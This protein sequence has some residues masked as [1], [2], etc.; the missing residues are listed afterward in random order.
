M[1]ACSKVR[2][3]KGRITNME[4]AAEWGEVGSSG[5]GTKVELS[6][7]A[8]LKEQEIKNYIGKNVSSSTPKSSEYGWILLLF[9]V[10]TLQISF[11]PLLQ[12]L[13]WT[14]I[15]PATFS[16]FTSSPLF[17]LPFTPPS[18]LACLAAST[19]RCIFLSR[20]CACLELRLLILPFQFNP[21]DISGGF[22]VTY[23]FNVR[24][25]QS[26]ILNK[27]EALGWEMNKIEFL[28]NTYFY[29]QEG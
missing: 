5:T 11:I 20:L 18:L 3:W 22:F 6:R 12:I 28:L 23:T 4:K 13:A 16:I 2:S 14:L 17:Q 9:L 7:S 1:G 27:D 24:N 29:L 26:F 8:E 25:S 10:F 21:T 15:H 19:L